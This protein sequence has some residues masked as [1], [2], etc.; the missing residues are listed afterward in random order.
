[1][2][3]CKTAS[4][5][6][7]KIAKTFKIFSGIILTCGLAYTHCMEMGNTREHFRLI[8]IPSDD[9]AS[10]A[11]YTYD[12]AMFPVTPS[13]LVRKFKHSKKVITTILRD[14]VFNI[15]LILCP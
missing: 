5:A 2:H 6:F 12:P 8:T 7:P 15:S 1:M 3:I 9:S 13:V 11:E 4:P 10:I 14:L